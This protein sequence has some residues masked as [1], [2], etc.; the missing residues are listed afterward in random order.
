MNEMSESR[1]NKLFVLR[2]PLLR[3]YIM[4]IGSA[5]LAQ[6]MEYISSFDYAR[7]VSMFRIFYSLTSRRCFAH[8]AL[9]LWWR[10]LLKAQ[11]FFI[12]YLRVCT[13]SAMQMEW[14]R[15]SGVC[16]IS[17][18]PL[19]TWMA[20]TNSGLGR[21]NCYSQSYPLQRY[22]QLARNIHTFKLE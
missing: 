1:T 12:P 10:Q 19:V 3:V 6:T 7:V 4:A 21:S 9:E 11:F 17:D 2:I 14:N 18:F 16:S 22:F 15:Y 5:N 13:Y 20:Y 8:S